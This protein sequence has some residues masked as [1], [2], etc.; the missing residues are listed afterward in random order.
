MTRPI[1]EPRSSASWSADARLPADHAQGDVR[2]FEVGADDYAEFRVGGQGGWSRQG[3]LDLAKDKTLSKP[4]AG[5]GARSSA[6]SGARRRGSGSSG[7]SKS[8]GQGR[9]DLHPARRRPRRLQRRR[10]GRQDHQAA[11]GAGH[12]HRGADRPG[13]RAGLGRLRRHLLRGGRRGLRQGRRHTFHDPIYV[14]DPGA[15]GAK[16]GDKVAIEMVRYP[17][18]VPRGR[19]GHHRDPRPARPAGRRHPLRHPRLQHPRRL[20]RRR[21]STRPASRPS[22]STRTTIERPARP[23]RRPDR[24]DRPGHRPRLRRRDLPRRATSGA[25]GAWASTSPTS[26]TSSAP[27]RRSTGRPGTAGRASTCPT[28]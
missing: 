6:C 12:E 24:H 22:S 27:A 17:T 11:Q 2:R 28:A 26:P 1:D 10:G 16:P 3:R 5:Q 7:R 14:G 18:P 19:G 13:P 23:P 8:A 20:R 25:T 4:R 15:K 21:R 9:P